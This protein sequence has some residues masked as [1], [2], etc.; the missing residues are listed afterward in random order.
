MIAMT[1]KILVSLG[2]GLFMLNVL[3][4][5]NDVQV[6]DPWVQAPPP[7]A[8]VLAAYM[9]LK[10]TGAKPQIV[11]AVSSPVFDRAEIHQTVIQEDM[12]RME[13]RHELTIPPNATATLKPGGLHL[14][15]IGPK[16][17]LQPGDPVSV[18]LTL[19]D[20]SALALTATVRAARMDAGGD[21]KNM[22][23]SRHDSH[24]H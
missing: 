17:K 11:T 4:G 6:I 5:S 14:M 1:K 16:K 21:R 24:A 10:N 12:T 19:K 15:L 2:L 20:G 18:T 3:A 7:N 23:H 9:Q 8:R 13:R 22:D